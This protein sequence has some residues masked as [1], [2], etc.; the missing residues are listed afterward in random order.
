MNRSGHSVATAAGFYRI[1]R[2]ELL[3]V[4]DDMALDCGRIRIRS[5]GSAGGH[6]GLS[7]IIGRLKSN[8]FAR[9]RMGIGPSE[10]PDSVDWE[11]QYTAPFTRPDREVE[12]TRAYVEFQRRLDAGEYGEVDSA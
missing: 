6:N 10:Y 3:V 11:G 7:D 1:D 2:S 4:T 8:E 9:L 5:K 12:M